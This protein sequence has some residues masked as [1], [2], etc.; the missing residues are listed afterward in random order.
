[1]PAFTLDSVTGSHGLATAT[2]AQ[3]GTAAAGR[4]RQLG[5]NAGGAFSRT[6]PSLLCAC[7]TGKVIIDGGTH[8]HD[9]VGPGPAGPERL[10]L[11]VGASEPP[12]R[13]GTVTTL[14][15][16]RPHFWPGPLQVVSLVSAR[17]RAW[18]T[19]GRTPWVLGR[20]VADYTQQVLCSL[21]LHRWRPP[22][23]LTWPAGGAP[24]AR[25]AAGREP[26]FKWSHSA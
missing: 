16:G 11:R 10:S 21:R 26:T 7:G 13:G 4:P 20:L 14:D 8:H 19:T 3:P 1:M 12:S 17:R 2:V 18:F 22:W 5:S 6:P 23:P 24:A 25:P 15:G 9:A